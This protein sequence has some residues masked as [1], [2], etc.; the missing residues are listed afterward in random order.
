M[1]EGT[2]KGGGG[3]GRGGGVQFSKLFRGGLLIKVEGWSLTDLEFFFGR[4]AK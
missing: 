3:G 2:F 4:G 1:D